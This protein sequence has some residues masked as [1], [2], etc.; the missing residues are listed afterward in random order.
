MKNNNAGGLYVQYEKG[1]NYDVRRGSINFVKWIRG[2]MEFPIQLTIFL[3]NNYQITTKQTKELVSAVFWGPYSLEEKPY[4]KVATGDFEDLV[5]QMGKY[6]AIAATLNSITHEL[7]HYQQWLINPRF[8][9]G[10]R[11]A[12]KKAREIVISYLQFLEE[13]LLIR[14]SALKSKRIKNAEDELISIFE[15]GNENIQILIIKEFANFNQSEKVKT[16][17]LQQVK[18][19]NYIIRSQ[20]VLSLS[21]FEGDSEIN[22]ICVNCLNDDNSLVRIR[23]AEVLR[24]IGNKNSIPHLI[25]ALGDKDELVR[26]YAAV[27]LGILGDSDIVDILKNMLKNEKRNAAKLRVYIGLFYLG[28][29]EFFDL[30]LKQLHSRSYLVRMAAAYYLP[31]IVDRSNLDK[32]KK[33]FYNGLLKEK[34]EEVRNLILKGIDYLENINF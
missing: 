10:E 28:Q 19:K 15:K 27:S 14:V 17:L 12:K 16:F 22:E 32:M 13:K 33:S 2:N 3:T 34:N 9:N 20:A 5:C 31:E 11:E 26:G 7:I 6:S 18:N 21:Y 25:N 4:I 24:D 30:I 23:A 29:T 8:K 1:V